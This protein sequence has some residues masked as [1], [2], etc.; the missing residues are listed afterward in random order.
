MAQLIEDYG[1]IGNAHSCALVGRDGSIDWLCA[2]RFDSAAAFAALLG[3]PTNGRWL[4]R[5]QAEV[6]ASERRYRP[7]TLILETRFTTAEGSVLLI[8]FMPAVENQWRLD[9]VRLV[10]G[11]AGCVDMAMALT[12]RFD[13][14]RS[15]PWMRGG[16]RPQAVAGPDGMTLTSPLPVEAAD[17]GWQARFPVAAGQRIPFQLTWHAGFR[18][19]PEPL[20]PETCLSEVER[21]WRSWCGRCRYDGPWRDA[22]VRSLITLKALTHRV[23]GGIVAAATTSLPESIG[24]VRNW[25][26]RYS[27]IRDSTFTLYAL[28]N[29]GYLSEAK[30]WRE[31][32]LRS[33]AGEPHQL[34]IMYGLGGERRLEEYTLPWLSGYWNSRPVRVGNAAH[35]QLQL[36]VFGE[37]MDS[38][39][40]AR[41]AGVEVEPEAWDVQKLFLDFLEGH[42]E[43]PDEGLW[44]VRGGGR[45]FTHS[46]VMAWVAVD[47]ALKAIDQFGLSG[48]RESWQALADRIHRDVLAHGYDAERNSFVQIY[49]GKAVDASLLMIPLVGF[50]PVDDPRV[51]GTVAAIEQD[52]LAGGLVHRY[53]CNT[54]LEGLPPGEG[55]FLACS[56]WLADNYALQGRRDEACQLFERLLGLRNDLGLLAEEYDTCCHRLLGN[57][58]QA[59]SHVALVNTAHNLATAF[60][61]ALQRASG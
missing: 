52:L 14:G 13:Y 61:P 39:H 41:K 33:V 4:I 44:E 5:P 30:A 23:T 21:R 55:T 49:G 46:K 6:L 58:P 12:P 45:Q 35:H 42:W 9:V 57:F 2:P 7:D 54:N 24:G 47:R 18:D 19:A 25:D 37:V 40:V 32:L 10:V 36:D 16:P 28:I 48:P 1:L 50:L 17:A 38:L 31:W 8:D 11:E 51:I 3:E 20:D 60:G 22:V 26:Y 15:I 43:D 29:S 59:F 27:W 56:F 53:L 34:Q